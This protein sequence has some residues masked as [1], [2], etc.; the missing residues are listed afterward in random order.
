MSGKGMSASG[1]F[2]AS[3]AGNGNS[4]SNSAGHSSGKNSMATSAKSSAKAS[5]KSTSYSIS[6]NYS[7]SSYTQNNTANVS[8]TVNVSFN[9]KAHQSPTPQRHNLNFKQ[10]TRE[11]VAIRNE[12]SQTLYANQKNWEHEKRKIST[13]A[14][15]EPSNDMMQIRYRN[16]NQ[17]Y[18]GKL[19]THR[20][21]IRHISVKFDTQ[22]KDVRASSNTLSKSFDQSNAQAQKAPTKEQVGKY[23]RPKINNNLNERTLEKGRGR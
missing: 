5:A 22:I 20:Q 6:S 2:S 15:P 18:S 1:A 3:S 4:G 19:A 16:I 7:V 8:P 13:T 10:S 21:S 17:E 23:Q 9:S 12:K 11:Q 14:F